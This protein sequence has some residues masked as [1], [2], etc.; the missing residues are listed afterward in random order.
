MVALTRGADPL[1][2]GDIDVP[3]P[4]SSV[5]RYETVNLLGLTLKL[6]TT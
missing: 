6:R 2:G 4:R 3:F 1:A 5:P